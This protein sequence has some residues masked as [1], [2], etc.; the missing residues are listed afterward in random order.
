MG[1]C[2]GDEKTHGCYKVPDASCKGRAA[3]VV[4]IVGLV[5]AAVFVVLNLVYRIPWLASLVMRHLPGFGIGALLAFICLIVG[6]V[7]YSMAVCCCTGEKGWNISSCILGVLTGVYVLS[8]AAIATSHGRI[9]AW[10]DCD[11]DDSG[12]KDLEQL[13]HT[14]FG[15]MYACVFVNMAFSGIASYLLKQAAPDWLA[16][17]DGD[18]PPVV[19]A[20]AADVEMANTKA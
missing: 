9:D 2:T 3:Q 12:C 7:T 16:M 8:I 17:G 4:S 14:I 20:A 15:I 1:C 11:D 10:L 19:M 13:I 5:I 6:V 18:A